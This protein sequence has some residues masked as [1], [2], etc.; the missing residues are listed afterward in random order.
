MRLLRSGDLLHR[1][2]FTGYSPRRETAFVMGVLKQAR[3]ANRVGKEW[4]RLYDLPSAY[5]PDQLEATRAIPDRDAAL[6]HLGDV[7]NR[8]GLTAGDA[9]VLGVEVVTRVDRTKDPVAA[10]IEVVDEVNT[11]RLKTVAG[12]PMKDY[13]SLAGAGLVAATALSL[14][15][16]EASIEYQEADPGMK[17]LRSYVESIESPLA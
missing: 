8:V 13:V 16:P 6:H 3:E 14:A 11:G 5:R 9:G 1:G 2:S 4:A 10:V 12:R 17:Q 15:R 7:A